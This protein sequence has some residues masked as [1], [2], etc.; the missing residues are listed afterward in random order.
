MNISDLFYLTLL[1]LKCMCD[2]G[3]GGGWFSVVAFS[4]CTC[5]LNRSDAVSYK[6]MRFCR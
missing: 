3:G 2:G 6:G 1:S 5:L 4:L